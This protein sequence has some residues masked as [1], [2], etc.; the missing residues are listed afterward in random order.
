MTDPLTRAES[1]ALLRSRIDESGLSARQFAIR[2]MIREP[3]TIQRW[4][5]GDSPIPRQV[6]RWLADPEQHPWTCNLTRR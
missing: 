3:R 1:V 6:I 5:A 4:L 2:V